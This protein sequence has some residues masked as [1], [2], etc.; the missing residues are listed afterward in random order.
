M[1]F[2]NVNFLLAEGPW[3][4]HIEETKSDLFCDVLW[5]NKL[6]LSIS[7]LVVFLMKY[8]KVGR[9]ARE[10]EKRLIDMEME[11]KQIARQGIALVDN[12]LASKMLV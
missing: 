11:I 6:P 7:V 8:R 5:N 4:I 10:N 3:P 1:L 2:R 12:K 9:K